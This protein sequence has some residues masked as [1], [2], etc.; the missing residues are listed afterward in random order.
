M[1]LISV[2]CVVCV[3]FRLSRETR[4]VTN[5]LLVRQFST[6]GREILKEEKDM[7]TILSVFNPGKGRKEKEIYLHQIVILLKI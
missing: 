6:L 7:G 1:A 5:G 3:G 4:Q 2:R